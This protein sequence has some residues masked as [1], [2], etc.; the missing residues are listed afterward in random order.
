MALLCM[1]AWMV[2]ATSVCMQPLR[3]TSVGI[4]CVQLLTKLLTHMNTLCA[5]EQTWLSALRHGF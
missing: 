3:F 4:L 1:A 2:A 5:S